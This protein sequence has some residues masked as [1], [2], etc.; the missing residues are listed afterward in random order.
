MFFKLPKLKCVIQT[1]TKVTLLLELLKTPELRKG[2][3]T[4]PLAPAEM[5]QLICQYPGAPRKIFSLSILNEAK[6]HY[7]LFYGAS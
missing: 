7:N 2:P 1:G 6:F 3:Q 5:I 4:L